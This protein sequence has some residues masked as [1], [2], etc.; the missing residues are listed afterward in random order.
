MNTAS[1]FKAGLARFRGFAEKAG[2][3]PSEITIALRV[4][5]GPGVKPRGAIEGEA[6]MFTGTDA[7]WVADIKALAGLGVSAVDVRLFG[8]GPNQSLEGTIDNMRRFRDGVLA[9]L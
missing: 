9:K 1:R 8:Y 4:L 5:S 3:D 6:E 2:R 7:D